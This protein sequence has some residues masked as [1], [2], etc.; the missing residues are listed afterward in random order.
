M[1]IVEYDNHHV[2]SFGSLSPLDFPAVGSVVTIGSFD[3]VHKGHRMII[4]RLVTLARSRQLRSVVVTFEPHPRRVLKGVVSGPL[5]LLTTLEEKINLLSREGV[6][7]LFVVRFTPDFAQRSSED[8]IRNVLV[9]LIG[10]KSIIIGYDHAFGRDRSGSGITLEHLCGELDF[11]VEVLDEVLIGDEH[12]SSTRIRQLLAS[13]LIKEANEFLGSPYMISGVVIDGD[14]RGREIGFP[15]VNLQLS[16]PDKLLPKSGVYYARTE[17]DGRSFRVMMNIGVRPTVSSE[18]IKTV[19]AYIL[20]Y[21]GNLYGRHL[22]FS[23]FRFIR[24]EE[25]FASV[26][27]LKGQLEKDKKT[28]E[29]YCL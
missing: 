19:E 5:G 10:A 15:T 25:Q 2:C 6:D 7:L 21:S 26:D 27:E 8:F 9:A 13:G 23:L 3:G 17:L 4:A 14:K 24:E 12:F 29:L 16:D 18:G 1:R 28:V 20:G 22:K 11:D